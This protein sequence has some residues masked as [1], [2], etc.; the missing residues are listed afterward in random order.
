[1]YPL[2]ESQLDRFA[3]RLSIGYP[4]A[5]AERAL[6]KQQRVQHPIENL[7]SVTDVHEVSEMQALGPHRRRAR[8]PV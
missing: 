4:N 1:V 6:M 8:Q 5:A 2:P 3:M 7:Q